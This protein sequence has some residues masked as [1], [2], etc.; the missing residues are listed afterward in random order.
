M[1]SFFYLLLISLTLSCGGSSESFLITATINGDNWTSNSLTNKLNDFGDI[2]EIK[3]TGEDRTRLVFTMIE[4]FISE[5][6]SKMP[7]DSL[8][9]PISSTVSFSAKPSLHDLNFQLDVFS[10]S[11]TISE[12]RVIYAE[13]DEPFTVL[14]GSQLTGGAFNKVWSI[15]NSRPSDNDYLFYQIEIVYENGQVWK[16][17]LAS[18]VTSFRAKYDKGA[19]QQEIDGEFYL[20]RL[21]RGQK[22]ISGDFFFNTQDHNISSGRIY[23]YNY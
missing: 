12:V 22:I 16:S 10:P 23:D 14:E 5:D 20:T 1:R 21:D 6:G 17:D 15:A 3:A 4:S 13:I 7:L 18:G 19:T 11:I 8:G 9:E 2:V